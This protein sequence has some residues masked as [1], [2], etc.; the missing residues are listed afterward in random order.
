M[1]T[2]D[3]CGRGGVKVAR[4][5]VGLGRSDSVCPACLAGLKARAAEVSRGRAALARED[6]LG[7]WLILGA[8]ALVFMELVLA[9]AYVTFLS[10]VG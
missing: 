9:A 3:W 2:C 5:P 6:A 7:A 1:N 4:V 10:V 8:V